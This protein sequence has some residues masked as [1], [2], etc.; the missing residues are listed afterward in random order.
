MSDDGFAREHLGYIANILEEKKQDYA[1]NHD[2]WQ[3]CKSARLKPE[4]KKAYGVKFSADGAKVTL[5][6][7]V[8]DSDGFARIT[9]I[10]EKETIYGTAWLA[11]WLNTRYNEAAC[12]V[13]DGRNGVDVLIDK[14]AG[15]WKMK[16]SIIK[17]TAS[18]MIAAVSTLLNEISEQTVTWYEQQ[19]LLN[20]SAMTS[21]KRAI[22]K[23]WGFGGEKPEPIEACALALW[24][25]RNS[26]R[27]PGK[28]MRIG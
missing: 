8:I 7:A 3:A 13:I 25:C 11:N 23:G 6:G 18:D 5:C 10:E 15:T 19:T 4:G 9:L 17:P 26:K 1:L 20:E 12:V 21:V 22:G 2:L 14:M 27:Q 16:G 28:Q 24:G